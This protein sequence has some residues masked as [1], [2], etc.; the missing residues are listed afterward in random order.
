MP[1]STTLA[2]RLGS[3]V[4]FFLRGGCAVGRGRGNRLEP[5]PLPT[6]LWFVVVV[7]D[8]QIPAKTASLY[9]RLTAEDFSDGSRITAQA[10]RLKAGL[11]LTQPCWETPSPAP[12]TPWPP[13]WPPCPTSCVTPVPR[14]S[15]SPE[16]APRTTRCSPVKLK[17]KRLPRASASDLGIVPKSSSPDP[18]RLGPSPGYELDTLR[19]WKRIVVHETLRN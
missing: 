5:L 9:A 11:P 12:S 7:P 1:S 17:P 2:A 16:P 15:L 14:R 18:R 19:G 13:S 10:A 4:P 8:V 6:D 3:D